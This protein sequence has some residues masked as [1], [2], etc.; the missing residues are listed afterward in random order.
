MHLKNM[1]LL[2]GLLAIASYSPAASAQHSSS[3]ED[4]QSQPNLEA[5]LQQSPYQ[6]QELLSKAL[7]IVHSMQAKKSC[8]SL[9]TLHLINE[10]KALEQGEDYI[11]A[12]HD[13]LL[14]DAQ[15]EYAA[16]LAVCELDQ[17]NAQIPRECRILLPSRE[18]C[19]KNRFPAWF[20]R[21][22]NPSKDECYYPY[23]SSKL[24]KCLPALEARGTAWTSYS[25]ARQ[26]AEVVC[27]ASREVVDKDKDLATY[28]SLTEVVGHMTEMVNNTIRDLHSWSNEILQF[29]EQIQN[30]QKDALQTSEQHRETTLS[31]FKN[32][33]NLFHSFNEVITKATNRHEEKSE[34]M[35]NSL[36]NFHTTIDEIRGA[37]ENQFQEI[38]SKNAELA[39]THNAQMQSTSDLAQAVI[40]ENKQAAISIVENVRILLAEAVMNTFNLVDGRLNSTLATAVLLNDKLED[41]EVTLGPAL[42]ALN[43][44]S[45]IIS[46]V[47]EIVRVV[48]N[49]PGP[50]L[51]GIVC[52]FGL[53]AAN[54][55]AAGYVIFL[56]GLCVIIFAIIRSPKTEG[57]EAQHF[58]IAPFT[59]AWASGVRHPVAFFAFVLGV[60]SGL[61]YFV[62]SYVQNCY[63]YQHRDEHGAVAVIPRIENRDNPFDPP[64]RRPKHLKLFKPLWS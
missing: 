44:F 19:V 24:R 47:S 58:L 31:G 12:D 40:E 17:A 57:F 35:S 64:P 9:A 61:S 10:C 21:Q 16:R 39:A 37:T 56:Y 43:S 2:C 3:Q 52:Y 5:L 23:E 18:A 45:A 48:L 1:R 36:T 38:Y 41:A 11:Q 25:N 20:S 42:E 34:A 51:G 30:S 27:R 29:V 22:V 46:F 28:K 33:M 63:L 49:N 60:I 53:R 50:W 14:D 7:N 8:F 6:Q 54:P 4:V 62:W 59:Y 13:T 26:N 15:S 55:K 32:I